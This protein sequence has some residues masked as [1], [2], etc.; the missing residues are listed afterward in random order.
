MTLLAALSVLLLWPL[1]QAAKLDPLS[2][3]AGGKS[4]DAFLT[5]HKLMV[6]QLQCPPGFRESRS[7]QPKHYQALI[8]SALPCPAFCCPAGYPECV[9]CLTRK[10]MEAAERKTVSWRF[11][12]SRGHSGKAFRSLVLDSLLRAAI[13]PRTW[14]Q[15][16]SSHRHSRLSRLTGSL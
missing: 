9:S 14:H 10:E 11:L 12:L 3:P 4:G 2:S 15:C 6:R 1:V 13:V 7:W 5:L 8:L 16:V